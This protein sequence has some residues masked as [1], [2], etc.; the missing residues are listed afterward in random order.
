MW[1][2][3]MRLS[4]YRCFS[5]TQKIELKPITLVLGKNNSGKSALVRAPLVWST[6]VQPNATVPLDLD[7]I[8]DLKIANTLFTWFWGTSWSGFFAGANS[9]GIK[10][11]LDQ[12]R[13][14]ARGE[15]AQPWSRERARALPQRYTLASARI[16]AFLIWDIKHFTN[17]LDWTGKPLDAA[18]ILAASDWRAY[19]TVVA[20]PEASNPANRLIFPTPLKTSV[21]RALLN[22]ADDIRPEVLKSHGISDAAYSALREG[23]ST[24]FVAERSK[25]LIAA[26]REFMKEMR[27]LP[28]V[29][30]DKGDDLLDSE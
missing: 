10:E 29:E 26:E 2:T 24:V 17:R 22:L 7:L 9:T 25:T 5:D 13:D 23:D 27:I 15:V 28:P 1:L 12:M 16:K 19:R 18:N 6:G 11:S 14:F 4:N 20:G 30:G 3:G 8:R 21:Q